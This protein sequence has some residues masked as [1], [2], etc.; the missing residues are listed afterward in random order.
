[1]LTKEHLLKYAISS[2]Q[3]CV[4]GQLTEPR[5]YGVYALP[6]DTDGTRRFRFGNHPMRQQELKHE[7]GSCTLYQLFLE[8]KDAESLAK[9][10]NKAI[11]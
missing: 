8:R 9:W 6:L 2:D 3:V 10:L 11:Q 1:M 7:F 4:K 5:S